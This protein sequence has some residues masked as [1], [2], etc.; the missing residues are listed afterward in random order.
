MVYLNVYQCLF[1]SIIQNV[2]PPYASFPQI[3]FLISSCL[4]AG[5]TPTAIVAGAY[6][7]CAL[8]DGGELVCWGSNSQGQLGLES[9]ISVGTLPADMGAS[10]QLVYLP[11]GVKRIYGK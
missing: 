6:H 5:N 4:G 7:T 9:T 8:L 11:P 2:R 10:L 1:S 3:F